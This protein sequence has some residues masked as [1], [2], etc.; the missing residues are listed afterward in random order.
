MVQVPIISNQPPLFG[1][2]KAMDD[3]LGKCEFIP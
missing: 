2:K 1:V 3:D